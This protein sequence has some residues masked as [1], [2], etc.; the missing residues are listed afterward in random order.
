MPRSIS[1][2]SSRKSVP[3]SACSAAPLRSLEAPVK[4]PLTWPKISLSIRSLGIAAQLTATK[5]PSS[6]LAELVQGL[7]AQFLA[8]ARFA[9]DE[10][11]RVG[12]GGA[13]QDPVD[14]L[15]RERLADEPP[16][17]AFAGLFDD[18]LEPIAQPAVLERVLHRHDQPVLRERLD[19]EVER[20][21]AHRFD[22]ELDRAFRGD[23]DHVGRARRALWNAMQDLEAVHVG[24]MDVEHRHGDRAPSR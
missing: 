12:R 18:F 16:G 10:H 6:P 9:G 13:A 7:G 2:T 11:G 19:D 5:G 4:A 1:P 24:Q 21:F 3:P 23:H 15:H 22:R 20:A 8:D 14:D 17:R